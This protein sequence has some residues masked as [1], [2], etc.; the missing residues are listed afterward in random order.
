[1]IKDFKINVSDEQISNINSKIKNYP[2]SSIEDMEGWIHGTNKK[3][4]KEL[5]D[6]WIVD[7]DWKV[8]E[9]LINSF[10]NFK[11]IGRAHV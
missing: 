8:H 1:M 7:F 9:K 3:Y 11:K 6:Y 10:S 5:C 2:W 4:L